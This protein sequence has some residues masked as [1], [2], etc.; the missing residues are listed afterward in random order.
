MD[1][2]CFTVVDECSL[3]LDTCGC[4]V[5]SGQGFLV[6]KNSL[7]YTNAWTVSTMPGAINSRLLGSLFYDEC[8][9][10]VQETPQSIYVTRRQKK[11]MKNIV[12]RRYIMSIPQ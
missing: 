9:E 6:R 10:L 4:E 11:T 1:D 8:D 12:L 3:F 5:F 7:I 2:Y